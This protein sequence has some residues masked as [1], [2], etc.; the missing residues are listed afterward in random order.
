LGSSP[1]CA[2]ATWIAAANRVMAGGDPVVLF[3]SQSQCQPNGTPLLILQT[4][5]R[6][7]GT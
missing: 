7:R 5:V 4:Q 6:V 1:A 3:D 2:C